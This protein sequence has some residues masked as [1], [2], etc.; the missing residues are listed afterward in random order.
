MKARQQSPN[1]CMVRPSPCSTRAAAGLEGYCA[2]DHYV[3]YVPLD[4]LGEPVTPS[5]VTTAR[6]RC[7]AAADIKSPIRALYPSH[8]R[9]AG[10]DG[11]R[12]PRLPKAALSMPAMSGRPPRPKRTGF[13]S[14]SI[15]SVRPMSGVAAVA[16]AMTVRVSSRPPSPPAVS[17][18]RA[19]PTSRPRRS[20]RSSTTMRNSD[21]AILSSPG[22]VGMMA[23]GERLLH[24]NAHWMAVTIEPLADI[25]AR[26]AD[27]HERPVTARRRVSP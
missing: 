15:V 5:H 2:H 12:F 25:I 3:G 7:C 11:G 20:A 21:E 24:A 6:H 19:T 1:C 9:L 27:K 22:H 14:R 18:H 10:T 26:L 4:T 17:R 23:D 13:P 16:W 8:A